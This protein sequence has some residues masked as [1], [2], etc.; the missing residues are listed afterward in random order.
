MYGN[1]SIVVHALRQQLA[2]YFL[3]P[4]YFS[5]SVTFQ[6]S[7]LSSNAFASSSNEI[8]AVPVMELSN[9]LVPRTEL[10][11]V[12]LYS[13]LPAY[14]RRGHMEPLCL[15]QG[16]KP[17]NGADQGLV[18]AISLPVDHLEEVYR[19]ADNES[20][21]GF[22]LVQPGKARL[23]HL[24]RKRSLHSANCTT[25][26]ERLQVVVQDIMQWKYLWF[27][28]AEWHWQ[29]APCGYLQVWIDGIHV[30]P[31]SD[32]AIEDDIL[33]EVWSW[34][35]KLDH[36]VT[37]NKKRHVIDVCQLGLGAEIRRIVLWHV[38]LP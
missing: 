32:A 19:F 35:H 28:C 38:L 7:E 13:M 24:D 23:D 22:S 25:S 11:A 14:G 5:T 10:R 30:Q 4:S 34:T 31:N 1:P 36:S 27:D 9:P 6:T 21:A 3:L 20:C 37:P 15:S 26:S 33:R 8:L 12:C 17:L 29:G 18:D 16:S 2:D